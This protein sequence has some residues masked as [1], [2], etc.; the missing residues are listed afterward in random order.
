MSRWTAKV[1]TFDIFIGEVH[2]Y[3]KNKNSPDQ[4]KANSL[5]ISEDVKGLEFEADVIEREMEKTIRYQK[6]LQNSE[7]RHREKT[8]SANSRALY[9][10]I[11]EASVL[12]S[13]GFIQIFYVRRMFKNRGGI[14]I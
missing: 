14:P 12:I 3:R 7:K 6:Y 9:L 11:L 10:A 5:L 13:I 1:V 2:E 8:D 4:P